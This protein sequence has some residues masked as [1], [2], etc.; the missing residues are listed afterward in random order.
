VIFGSLYKSSDWKH[1]LQKRMSGD[2]LAHIPGKLPE[3]LDIINGEGPNFTNEESERI[4]KGL[5][6]AAREQDSR[7]LIIES[8]LVIDRDVF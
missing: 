2:G 5:A 1:L 7:D 4:L 8:H 6:D 3:L